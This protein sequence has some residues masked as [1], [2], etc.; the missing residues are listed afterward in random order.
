MI[1]LLMINITSFFLMGLDKAR[2]KKNRWR[3]SEK[4]LFLS[5]FLGGAI[6]AWLGMYT[7]HHKTRHWYFVVGMAVLSVAEIL[8]I[9]R[10]A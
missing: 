1:Y 6:G 9:L 10:L 2:A 3:I 5:A 8:F 7:F 4:M